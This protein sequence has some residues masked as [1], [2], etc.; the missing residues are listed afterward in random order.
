MDTNEY[1]TN[2]YD[3]M[4]IQKAFDILEIS[5]DENIDREY[6]KK[7]YHKLA[8]KWHPDKNQE[9]CAK[10]KFQLINEA[11]E[12]LLNELFWDELNENSD[13]FVSSSETEQSKLYINIL[14]SFVSSLFNGTYNDMLLNILKEISLGYE[15]VTLL[16]LRKKCETLDKQKVIEL[17]HLL[18]KY[19]HILYIS[20]NTLELVSLII[21]E[22]YKNDKIFILQ[23]CLEDIMDHKIYK[24][25]VDDQLYLVP[26]WHNELYFDGPDGT[27]IIVLC[28]PQLPTN[29]TIDENNNIYCDK[30][31][32]INSELLNSKFVSLEIGDKLFLIPLSKL[33]IKDEQIYKLKDQ[34]I[35]KIIE[36]DIYNI[37]NKSDIIVKII[38]DIT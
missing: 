21:K 5:L 28:Q 1:Y 17:Y 14:S 3:T 7:K 16:Y 12:Y 37:T 34:G 13:T 4:S 2:E 30:M 10:A 25:Y 33:Y 38:L 26:L 36:K 11:Y 22:K 24:L 32:K 9:E 19:K 29:I 20:D 6:V 18:Y 35:S 27:E 15:T 8:L 23:P 31:I